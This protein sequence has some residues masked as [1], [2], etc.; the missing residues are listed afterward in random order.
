MSVIGAYSTTAQVVVNVTNSR[1]G[2]AGMLAAG[3]LEAA[4]RVVDGVMGPPEDDATFARITDRRGRP[5][6]VQA[7]ELCAGCGCWG[8]SG[9]LVVP[10]PGLSAAAGRRRARLAHLSHSVP[11]LHVKKD[12]R[13]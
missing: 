13:A 1:G 7:P 2:C 8:C 9:Q 4:A 3:A 12:K 6:H 10:W 5:A 11:K